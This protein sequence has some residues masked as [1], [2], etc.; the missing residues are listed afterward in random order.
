MSE[1]EIRDRD[2]FNQ[3]ASTYCAKDLARSS[4]A[5]RKLRLV[6]SLRR[7]PWKPGMS[8]LEIGCG[9]GFT[10][11]YVAG[12]YQEYVGVD[13]SDELIDYA[14]AHHGGPGVRFEPVN[15]KDFRDHRSFDVALMIG[16]LHHLDDLQETLGGIMGLIKP[17]GW[18]V[19]N[20][21]HPANPAIHMARRMRKSI[22]RKYSSDQKELSGR[23]LRQALDDAGFREVSLVPQGVFS[24]PFAEVPLRPEAFWAPVCHLACLMDRAVEASLG[25]LLY[26]LSWNLVVIGR[27]PDGARPVNSTPKASGS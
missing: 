16:V 20:E 27:K 17:G 6:Q 19:A 23:E 3:I 13:Y 24:T 18:L 10:A 12:R 5:A 8:I 7:V 4:K 2:L 21:P 22:D 9:G 14:R 15:I 25:R 11:E 1:H 26:P